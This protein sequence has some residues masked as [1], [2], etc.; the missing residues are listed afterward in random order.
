MILFGPLAIVGY[1]FVINL[2]K[3]SS[4]SLFCSEQVEVG[5]ISLTNVKI[6]INFLFFYSCSSVTPFQ[7]VKLDSVKIANERLQDNSYWGKVL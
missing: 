3:K 6:V 5:I 7:W 2:A 1:Y 4:S